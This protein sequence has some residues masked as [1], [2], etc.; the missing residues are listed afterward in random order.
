MDVCPNRVKIINLAGM[1]IVQYSLYINQIC[2]VDWKLNAQQAILF[3]FVFTL[4][5]WADSHFIDGVRFYRINKT[6]IVYELPM[7]T[8]KPDTIY[9]LLKALEEKGL[10][11]LSNT[12]KS[13]L[14]ALTDKA[15]LW[16]SDTI[17][18]DP[19]Q[20][21]ELE[22]TNQGSKMSEINPSNMEN[23]PSKTPFISE[24]FPYNQS[25]NNQSTNN[26]SSRITKPES[27]K[28]FFELYPINKKGG[29][30]TSAWEKAKRMKLTDD[31]F[32]AMIANLTARQK[33]TPLWYRRFAPKITSYLGDYVWE[34]PIVEE[35]E[36][37]GKGKSANQR[38][39]EATFG[40]KGG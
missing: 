17:F 30:D 2:A 29:R 26:Q 6:K 32:Q 36:N 28:R 24:N 33:L 27:F 5:S 23:Y 31:D 35:G 25:T 3:S 14:V 10:I 8:D 9:R 38:I 7:L 12:R 11:V 34:A 4:P 39:I 20:E 13:T 1:I 16:T 21:F 18:I 37:D 19:D 40:T 15:K 22:Q